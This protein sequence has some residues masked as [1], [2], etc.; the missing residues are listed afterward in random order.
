MR[1]GRDCSRRA[2]LIVLPILPSS[3]ASAP[4]SLATLLAGVVRDARR[5]DLAWP[6]FPTS[7]RYRRCVI[8]KVEEVLAREPCRDD[9]RGPAQVFLIGK[10]GGVK[11]REG[12][13]RVSLPA[14]YTLIDGMPMRRR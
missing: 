11:L 14:I 2:L 4:V 1:S 13:D 5:P 3:A 7:R 9:A 8:L 12:G 10:D 6:E